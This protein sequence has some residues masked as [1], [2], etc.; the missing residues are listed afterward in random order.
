MIYDE[1]NKFFS[2]AP[3]VDK[4]GFLQEVHRVAQEPAIEPKDLYL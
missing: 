2:R 1:V 3:G 4:D